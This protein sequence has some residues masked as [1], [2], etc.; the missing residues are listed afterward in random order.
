MFEKLKKRLHEW[1]YG[2][3][4]YLVYTMGKV[5]STTFE[6]AL[7]KQYKFLP[8]FKL[9]F[10][11]DYWIKEVIPKMAEGFHQNIGIARQFEKFRSAHPDYRLKIITMV[12]EPVSRDISDIFQ[13]W[14][15]FFDTNRISELSPQKILDYLGH[16]KFEYTLNWFDTEFKKWTGKNIYEMKFDKE[17]GY[18]IWSF[19]EFDLLCVKLEKLD[20]VLKEASREFFRFD[21]SAEVKAN[22]AEEKDIKDL[23]RLVMR[24][25]KLNPV[26]EDLVYHSKLVNHFYTAEEIAQQRSRW[27]RSPKSIT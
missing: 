8:V 14:Q 3:N 19:E 24:D 6:T 11:S 4:I 16:H 18:T 22:T 9:H 7:E 12:R 2:K 26:Q 13:N 1:R 23:Y 10:L 17:K 21:I 20:S 27:T 25:F 15:I 5:G